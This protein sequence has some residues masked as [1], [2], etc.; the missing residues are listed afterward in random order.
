LTIWKGAVFNGTCEMPP[1]QR[2]GVTV[3]APQEMQGPQP[4]A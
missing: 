2:H 1:A 3:S 4:S